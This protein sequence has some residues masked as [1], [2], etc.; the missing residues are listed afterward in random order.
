MVKWVIITVAVAIAFSVLYIKLVERLDLKKPPDAAEVEILKDVFLTFS[1]TS[2][3]KPTLPGNRFRGF[4]A[5]SEV[6]AFLVKLEQING[7]N[8]SNITLIEKRVHSITNEV[9]VFELLSVSTRI[10]KFEQVDNGPWRVVS[11]NIRVN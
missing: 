6:D 3:M 9:V 5:E 4:A 11:S 8:Y 10:V 7:M 1:H 2:S